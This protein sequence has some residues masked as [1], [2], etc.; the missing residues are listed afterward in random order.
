MMMRSAALLLAVAAPAALGFDYESNG[1]FNVTSTSRVSLTLPASTGCGTFCDVTVD[2]MLPLSAHATLP[3]A[4]FSPGFTMGTND[5]KL[6]GDRLAS[7]GYAVVFWEP[8]TEGPLRFLTQAA[9][10]KAVSSVIDWARDNLAADTNNVFA[11]GHSAGGKSSV[12]AASEDSRIKGVLGIDAVDCP[13]PGQAYGDDFPAGVDLMSSTA[14]EY[15]WIGSELGPVPVLGQPC[16][17]AECGF[18]SY[19][20]NSPSPAWVVEILDAGH[21]QFLDSRG[22]SDICPTGDVSDA[23]VRG[24]TNT[25]AVAWAERTTRGVNI[26]E[27]LSNWAE[28]QQ[29]QGA[30]KS[31]V[32]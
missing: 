17:P 2:A 13:P 11:L 32:K 31:T 7:H 30:I 1:P 10:G 6:I 29:A 8:G 19:Y 22:A 28:Q 20:G 27:Y 15:A 12:L 25:I 26:D 16:A 3:L 5:Y 14:A 9:R 24:L 4:V 18:E 21:N 23:A